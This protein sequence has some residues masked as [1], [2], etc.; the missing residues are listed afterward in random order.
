MHVGKTHTKSS[1]VYTMAMEDGT[2]KELEVTRVEKDLGVQISDNL[3]VREQVE[4]AVST[5]TRALDKLKKAFRSRSFTLWRELYLCYIRPHLEFAAIKNLSSEERNHRL[6]LT[7]LEKRRERGDLIEQFKIIK[8]IDEVNF[9]V[10][11]TKPEWQANK[12]YCLRGNNCHLKPQFVKGCEERRH[13][14]TNRVTTAW[15][16]L[17]QS[18]IDATSVNAFK[19]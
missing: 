6:G 13:F 12:A 16:N 15:N 17:P 3:K 14:F 18:A 4:T 8:N 19:D 5:A 7:T 10:A 1:H 11:Q 9:F 2:R